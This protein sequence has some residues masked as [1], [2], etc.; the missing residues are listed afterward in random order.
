MFHLRNITLV[1]AHND[2]A[3]FNK[4][5]GGSDVACASKKFSKNNSSVLIPRF[6]V[7]YARVRSR[8]V[9]DAGTRRGG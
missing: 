8:S 9:F 7:Y 1:I 5:N 3:C 6:W 2:V 4:T